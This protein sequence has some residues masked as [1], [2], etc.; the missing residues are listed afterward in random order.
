MQNACTGCLL[1]QRRRLTREIVAVQ[2][3]QSEAH[4]P[5]GVAWR[6]A[7]T[8]PVAVQGDNLELRE[9]VPVR[10]VGWQ[11]PQESVVS[12]VPVPYD[13]LSGSDT[14]ACGISGT[15]WLRT[16]AQPFAA[17][18]DDLQ[19]KASGPK[20]CQ[21]G[22]RLSAITS[23]ILTPAAIEPSNDRVDILPSSSRLL[24]LEIHSDTAATNRCSAIL[25]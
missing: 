20:T 13:N 23:L 3:E 24:L 14:E 5:L 25:Y 8:Q 4:Q 22:G 6:Q 7:A 21:L 17:W 18:T 15:L 19:L 11:A 2:V 10:P 16:T 9:H 12:Q 1:C